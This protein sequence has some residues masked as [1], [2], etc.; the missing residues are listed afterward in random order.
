MVDVPTLPGY[1]IL[2]RIGGGG[3]GDVYLARQLSLNRCVAIKFFNEV[4]DGERASRLARIERES[5]LLADL[6]CSNIVTVF[7]RGVAD[8]RPYLVMEYVD[9]CTLREHIQANRPMELDRSRLLLLAVGRAV[10][11]L[12]NRDILHRDLKPENVFVDQQDNVKVGDLGIAAMRTD[13]GAITQ[14]G[15]LVGTIDYMAP[16]QRHRLPVDQRA[17]QFAVA[18]MAYEMLTGRKPLGSF[19]PPSTLNCRL[20]KE[21]DAIILRGLQREPDDRFLTVDDFSSRLDESLAECV[22]AVN[23]LQPNVTAEIGQ[24]GARVRQWW[25]AI[26]VISSIL[27]LGCVVVIGA[28]RHANRRSPSASIPNHQTHGEQ[29]Q[30]IEQTG[31]LPYRMGNTGWQ[32]LLVRT[33]RDSHWTI[34]KSTRSSGVTDVEAAAEE[35]YE[36]AGIRG[37]AL[38][39]SLGSYSYT[40]NGKHYRVHVYPVLVETEL[41]TWPEAFRA[42]KWSTTQVA[43]DSVSSDELR[44]MIREF[45]VEM[46]Q[47]PNEVAGIE[48][49]L[50]EDQ[51]QGNR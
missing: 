18:V 22:T 48:N 13:L 32:I 28:S 27:L 7:D 19:E 41:A 4:S 20:S 2:E 31:A 1:E 16:E 36:E 44:E 24:R 35:A 3:N 14:S 12:H 42:R 49:R 6:A 50:S 30:N 38:A 47:Q 33:R 51:P 46:K 39:T 34:P 15:E 9:G 37:V 8:G 5:Q 23:D 43:A 11:Y 45:D 21:V 40:R 26:L 25:P 17:D 10:T 29:P